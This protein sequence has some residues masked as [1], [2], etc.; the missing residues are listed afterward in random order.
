MKTDLQEILSSF[1]LSYNEGVVY[2]TL[3]EY[4]QLSAKR[5]SLLSKV[6]RVRTYQVLELLV[7]KDLVVK[8]NGAKIVRFEAVHPEMLNS[9]ITNRVQKLEHSKYSFE[10]ILPSIISNYNKGL[11]RPSISFY[12]C[13]EGFR[14][15]YDDILAEG[16]SI[17]II[18]S[19]IKY[20]EYQKIIQEYKKKQ[21]KAGIVRYAIVQR[22]NDP[23]V[24]SEKRD[25]NVK[26]ILREDL[27]LPGQILI[28]GEKVAITNFTEEV[29]HFV[30]QNKS[31]SQM[32]LKMFSFIRENYSKKLID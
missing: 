2:S 26:R 14:K 5:I 30:I 16:K 27:D 23:N 10:S 21:E 11:N 31:I 6:P 22:D 20:P 24:K 18:A 1:G 12:E 4:G 3:V 29:S 8:K 7:N 17:H 9:Y 28:Y 25:K 32:F 15:I 19:S 13:V